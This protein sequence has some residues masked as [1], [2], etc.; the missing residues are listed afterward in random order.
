MHD[1]YPSE[2]EPGVGNYTRS[3]ILAAASFV[4]L[5]VLV[6]FFFFMGGSPP[7]ATNRAS[8]PTQSDESG[9]ETARQD[10]SRQTDANAC[11]NALQKINAE[12]S[13]KASLRPPALSNEE[14]EFLRANLSLSSEELSEVESSH[15]TR[16]D[17]HHLFHCLLF[18]D[19]ASALRKGV[20]GKV[21]G[22][23]VRDKPLD[24]AARAFAWVMR[25]VRLRPQEGEAAPPT[26]VV[27]RGWGSALERALV[28][29]ALLEQLGEP[30]APQPELL[31]FLLQVPDAEGRMRLWACGVV[32]GDAKEVYLF[33]PYFGLPLPGPKGEGIA[34][35]AEARTKSEILSQLN[36]DKYRYPAT[37]EQARSAQA[38]LVCPLSEL[39]P[40]MRYLQDKLLGPAVRVRL[41]SDAA[42]D[43]ER[44]KTACSTGAEKAT[45]ALIPK[46][47]CTLLRRFLS[48]DEG[49]ADTTHREQLFVRNLVPWDALPTV[50]QNEQLFPQKSALGMQVRLIFARQF[51][52]P[53]TEPNQPRDLLLRGRI[54]SAEEKLVAERDAGR[55]ILAQWANIGDMQK[56][57]QAWLDE[58]TRVYA[59]ILRAKSSEERQ[60]AEKQLDKLW[61]D[62][63]SYPVHILLNS[64]AATAR[65]PEVA[66]QLGLCSQEEAEQVQARL[67][68]QA[69]IGVKPQPSDVAKA[70]LAWQKA[71]Q[72]WKSFEDE[73]PLRKDGTSTH[74]DG[75]VA[76]RLRGRAESMLG[77]HKAAVASWKKA[78]AY[79]QSDPEKIASLY[80]AQQWE[81]QNA[82]KGK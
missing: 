5:L 9:A 81:K 39:S 28:F 45:P 20:R 51:V 82:G 16:L 73:Y 64:A 10:L 27:R 6:G 75:A 1:D 23:N 49:G 71:L 58:A 33:D 42:K 19:A 2:L 60:Q 72:N 36:I 17:Q 18:R 68:L 50:F 79:P 66:Y 30:D 24:Q 7:P 80:L 40:R 34:T 22:Q 69:R 41:A 57:F 43:L 52:T 48:T 44:I 76:C 4:L 77:D 63:S 15:Y 25:E 59:A 70:Q 12:L 54:G 53:V 38:Q 35:L 21:G 11:R 32:A 67:D 37:M 3:W 14:K 74:P 78:A 62:R 65:N 8:T 56:Q 31:G 61:K 26:F 46:D 29:L 55:S 47:Q 13:E